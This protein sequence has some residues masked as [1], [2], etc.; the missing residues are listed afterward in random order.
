M[1]ERY[2][3]VQYLVYYETLYDIRNDTYKK[4]F[5]RSTFFEDKIK[6]I[7]KIMLSIIAF[8]RLWWLFRGVSRHAHV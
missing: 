1:K 3:Q 8:T 4:E 7:V 2:L 6:S 5:F